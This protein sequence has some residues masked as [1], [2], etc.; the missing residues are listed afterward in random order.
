MYRRGVCG[1]AWNWC[2]Q[3]GG[4]QYHCCKVW[5]R[6]KNVG[7]RSGKGGSQYYWTKVLE[8]NVEAFGKLDQF[9]TTRNLI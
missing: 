7:S 8:N 4:D 5:R 3:V 6:G 1:H 2:N 9:G